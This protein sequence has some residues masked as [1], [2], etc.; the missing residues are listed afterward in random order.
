[1]PG[2]D[3]QREAWEKRYAAARERFEAHRK[4][5]E[6]AQKAD[7]DAAVENGEASS[8][9]SEAPEE[10]RRT[11]ASDEA[12]GRA[13]GE[14]RRSLTDRS[15]RPHRPGLGSAAVAARGAVRW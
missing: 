15:P 12:L 1:M 14:A 10:Q 5:L 11:L 4:Q 2:Y 7:A 13:A 9:T 6:D 8:Y 3:E